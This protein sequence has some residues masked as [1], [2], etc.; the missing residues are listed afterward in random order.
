MTISEKEETKKNISFS[1]KLDWKLLY[2]FRWSN[3]RELPKSKSCYDVL[4]LLD[5]GHTNEHTN[6]HIYIYIY[7]YIYK[8]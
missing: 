6:N 1:C 5:H 8:K 3:I 4:F 2:S 7:I